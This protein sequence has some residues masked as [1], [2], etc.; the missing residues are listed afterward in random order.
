M[1]I[2][3]RITVTGLV[4]SNSLNNSTLATCC[5]LNCLSFQGHSKRHKVV[6]GNETVRSCV[7]TWYKYTP[8]GILQT[9][10]KYVA[11]WISQSIL[12]TK[13]QYIL[14]HH[15]NVIYCHDDPRSSAENEHGGTSMEFTC[16]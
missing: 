6:T 11:N 4:M 14:V 5:K 15:R 13:N 8:R 1:C 10:S 7:Y 12:I 9:S 16:W 3:D 2:A